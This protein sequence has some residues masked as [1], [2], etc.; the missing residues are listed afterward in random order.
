MTG[1]PGARGVLKRELQRLC[2]PDHMRTCRQ[3]VSSLQ[4][5]R[6]L[7]CRAWGPDL[8]WPDLGREGPGRCGGPRVGVSAADGSAYGV[9]RFSQT[10]LF[11]TLSGVMARPQCVSEWDARKL[12]AHSRCADDG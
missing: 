3:L 5:V 2:A 10:R 6:R 4:A 7:S 9:T 8:A 11:E 1:R 12:D